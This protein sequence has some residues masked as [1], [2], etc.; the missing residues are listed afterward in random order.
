VGSAPQAESSERRSGEQ[1]LRPAAA[2]SR[3][4]KALGHLGLAGLALATIP[5]AAPGARLVPAALKGAPGWME[6]IYGGG[7]GVSPEAYYALLWLAFASYLCV[8]L[9]APALNRQMLLGAC[10]TVVAAFAL[11]PPLLSQDVFSYIDYARLGVIH[12]LNPY[13]HAPVDAAGDAA[14]PFVGWADSSSA[15]GPLFTAGTYPLAWV[16]VP[17]A[18]WLLKGAAAASVLG[19]AVLVAR[20]AP[21]RGLDSNRALVMVALNP[22]VLVHIVG[23]AHNDAV[24]MLL[25]TGGCAAVLARR[26]AS[27]GFALLTAAA[28]KVSS[29]FM[30]PFA[31]LGTLGPSKARRYGGMWQPATGRLGRAGRLLTGMAL[32]LLAIGAVAL[33]FF[34]THALD[35]LGLAGE[36]QAR[37]SNYSL[38][39]LLAE[40]LGADVDTVRALALGAYCLLLVALLVWVWRGADWIRAAGWAG[41]A[42][43]LASAWLLPW[44]V[45]W[46]LPLAAL[47]RDG[48]LVALVLALSALQLAARVPL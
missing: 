15:Y 17:V 31:L 9:A 30:I 48:R 33:I 41:L 21:A 46:V 22:L 16:S 14:F 2:A 6:G 1:P 47:S 20:L 38:P 8:L 19:L 24:T 25:A 29:A 11:A 36:N 28:V 43:L 12:E 18:L 39:N 45:I 26:E 13:S 27:G 3:R 35:S 10:L 32:A 34:G 4:R 7:L 5:L 42:L 37:V 23:G 44:Y 40:F